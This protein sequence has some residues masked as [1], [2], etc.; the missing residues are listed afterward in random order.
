M[1]DTFRNRV[2]TYYVFCLVFLTDLNRTMFFFFPDDHMNA[3]WDFFL[4]GNSLTYFGVRN[5]GRQACRLN[6]EKLIFEAVD[7]LSIPDPLING[8]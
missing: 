8:V 6:V 1:Y 2:S 4:G 5:C 7:L 3:R